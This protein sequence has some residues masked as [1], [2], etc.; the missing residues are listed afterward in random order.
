MLNIVSEAI[1][2]FYKKKDHCSLKTHCRRKL[3][4]FK[5]VKDCIKKHELV[6]IESP[7]K[8]FIARDWVVCFDDCKEGE[9]EASF[10]TIFKISKIAPV[11]YVKHEFSV[12]NKDANVFD[13]ML[14]GFS[15]EGYIIPQGNLHWEIAE[16]FNKKGYH[17]LTY[18]DIIETVEG[19]NMPEGVTIFGPNVTVEHLLF[20]DIFGI[21]KKV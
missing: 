20:V 9:F 21:R 11:F 8:G 12:K 5:E 14:N 17:E 3:E 10:R 7:D 13:K 16:I 15:G 6:L 18:A 4:L 19:F 1:D 2:Q